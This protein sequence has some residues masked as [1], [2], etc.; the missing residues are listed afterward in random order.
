MTE[1]CIKSLT[2]I[3]AVSDYI[4]RCAESLFRQTLEEIQ[5]IFVDDASP[6]D[7]VARLEQTLE[8]F[9]NRKA[10]TIILHHP[11]HRSLPEARAT[12]LAYAQAP[13]VAHCDSDDYVEPDMYERLY[14]TAV[15]E[16][17]DMVI[18]DSVFH[19]RNGTQVIS[20]SWRVSSNDPLNDFIYGR[21]RRTVWCRLTKT[22]I[23]R[24]VEF[25]A[26]NY[27]EDWVQVVQLLA[28]CQN[29]A[30]LP[31]PLYH[32]MQNPKSIMGDRRLAVVEESVRQCKANYAKVHDFLIEKRLALESDFTEMKT[33]V[34]TRYYPLLLRFRGR[35][36]YLQTFPELN[37]QLLSSPYI[38]KPYKFAHICILLGIF[39]LVYPI[40][41]PLHRRY[42]AWR[43]S[44]LVSI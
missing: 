41:Q 20:R 9:P 5:F 22:D 44:S 32:Q 2:P 38:E 18:C 30:Y 33:F 28:Y 17:A 7:S 24:R 11:H 4:E 43:R 35:R 14:N 37:A 25:S 36:T 26:D 3:Y 19:Y 12:G 10:H 42:L 1:R 31:E 6:D 8:R 15:I 40:A 16:K 29:V 39:P 13:F 23:Y 27:M 21:S 34:R